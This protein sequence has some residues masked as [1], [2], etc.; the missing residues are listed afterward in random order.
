L[1]HVILS[2]MIVTLL[3]VPLPLSGSSQ[4]LAQVSQTSS[5]WREWSELDH[6]W[7]QEKRAIEKEAKRFRAHRARRDGKRSLK[8]P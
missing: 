2:L 1:Y 3:T 8:Q 4:A 6:L 5:L 7:R